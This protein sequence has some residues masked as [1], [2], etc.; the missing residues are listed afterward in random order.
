MPT[1]YHPSFEI[2]KPIEQIVGVKMGLQIDP[3]K[4]LCRD[5]ELSGF[6]NRDCSAIFADQYQADNY[7]EK[8]GFTLAHEIEH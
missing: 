3:I 5:F 7:G 4:N 8:C 1:E 2:P 6:L